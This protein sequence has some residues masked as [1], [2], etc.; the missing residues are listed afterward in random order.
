MKQWNAFLL[1][2]IKQ[3][4]IQ[5]G[6]LKPVQHYL[7]HIPHMIEKQGVL[8]AYSGRSME[9]TIGR[10]K[11]LIKS[12]VDA[13][14]NAGNVMERFTIYG[15]VNSLNIDI[16]EALNL[17]EPKQY[18]TNTFLSLD[19]NDTTTPQLWSPISR[20]SVTSLPS[21]VSAAKFHTA[22]VKYHQNFANTVDISLSFNNTTFTIA[23]RAWYNNCTYTSTLYK[24]HINETRRGNN[25]VMFEAAY[26]K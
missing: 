7:T 11:K 19:P 14:A 10:Y 4:R 1:D 12:K 25:Y 3:K 26:L 21:S 9:R 23:G 15:Y 8:K 5:A 18:S 2:E 6:V 16:R 22:L 24:D 13:G 17:L 20:H